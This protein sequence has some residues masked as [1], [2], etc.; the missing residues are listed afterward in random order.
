MPQATFKIGRIFLSF[1][2]MLPRPRRK[3]ITQPK[4]TLMHSPSPA[5]PLLDFVGHVSALPFHIVND[6]V[7]GGA[8]GY[9]AGP[10]RRATGDVRAE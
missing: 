10:F 6:G 8:S 4:I 7:M 1:R 5:L 2:I 3:S 9:H